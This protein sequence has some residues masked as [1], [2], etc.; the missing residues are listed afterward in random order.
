MPLL[1]MK[2][3][4]PGCGYSS[5][6]VSSGIVMT[7]PEKSQSDLHFAKSRSMNQL[8]PPATHRSSNKLDYWNPGLT[9]ADDATIILSVRSR[10]SP[11]RALV[12]LRSSHGFLSKYNLHD[13]H[14]RD[15]R[16]TGM[17]MRRRLEQNRDA[18]RT[19]LKR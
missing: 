14:D 12:R 9:C 11:A 3:S 8:S 7:L 1:E 16:V 4:L 15:G 13:S 6:L 19:E 18:T 17:E 5:L 10:F 2:S